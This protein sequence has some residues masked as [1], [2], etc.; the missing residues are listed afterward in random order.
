MAVMVFAEGCQFPYTLEYGNNK[1]EKKP[2][3]VDL[4]PLI[5]DY[6]LEMISAIALAGI[7]HDGDAK[8]ENAVKKALYRKR[9]VEHVKGIRNCPFVLP[10][11]KK[12]ALTDSGVL[13]DRGAPGLIAEIEAAFQIHSRLTEKQT[14]N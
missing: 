2:M 14:K 12:E 6:S 7:E 11:G 1:K 5:N 8:A 9:F 13:Y 10:S 4:A 3:E